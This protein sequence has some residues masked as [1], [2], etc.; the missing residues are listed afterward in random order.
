MLR[1]ELGQGAHG[2]NKLAKARP[3][4]DKGGVPPAKAQRAAAILRAIDAHVAE[5]SSTS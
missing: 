1:K 5:N 2:L 4:L 3:P